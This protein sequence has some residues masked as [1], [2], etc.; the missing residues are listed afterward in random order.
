MKETRAQ[1]EDG[2][3][4][5]P[6]AT[7]EQ[8]SENGNMTSCLSSYCCFEF[9]HR[10]VIATGVLL[11]LRSPC[12]NCLPHPFQSQMHHCL[13]VQ[14]LLVLIFSHLDMRDHSNSLSY[15]YSDREH[16]LQ[17]LAVLARTCSTFREPALDR[18]WMS[19]ALLNLIRCMP[20][21]LWLVDEVGEH[22]WKYNMVS[23]LAWSWSISDTPL[24]MHVDLFERMIGIECSY[25]RL[26]F[27]ISA[28]LPG[29]VTCREFSQ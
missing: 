13:R 17:D 1:R 14:E 22:P 18:L 20:G 21:D 10:L 12:T 24:S 26:A 4:S 5:L 19:S 15:V 28:S 11:P 27:G 8:N 2:T 3:L 25:T 16:T 9:A 23:R 6:P 7:R 29:I